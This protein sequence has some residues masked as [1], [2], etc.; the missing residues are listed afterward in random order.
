MSKK[1]TIQKNS[2][3]ETLLIPLYARKICTDLYPSIFQD[4]SAAETID[5]IDYDFTALAQKMNSLM[6]RFGALETAMR[7]YDLSCE[8]KEYLNHHPYASVVNMG[9]GLDQTGE[10]CD[11]GTCKIYNLDFPDVIAVRNELIPE[12][13]RIRNLPVDLND[14]EWFDKIDSSNGVIFIAAGVFYYF[15]TVEVQSLLK[16]MSEKFKGGKLIFD[17]AGKRAV[18]IMTKKL[19]HKVG[20][21][22]VDAYFY[23]NDIKTDISP[24]LSEAAVSS[25]GY[26]LGYH[27]LKDPSVSSLFRLFSGIGDGFMKM[28]IIKIEF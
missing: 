9:C 8:V 3:Q 1:I 14:T 12:G 2:V 10:S 6:G 15:K 21:S 25:R 18:K 24:W 4:H 17:S 26:M 23:V 27:N 22:E 28:K 20:I 19:I 5:Q 7:Q 16:A 13:G 11:N